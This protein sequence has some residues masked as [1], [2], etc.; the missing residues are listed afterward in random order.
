MRMDLGHAVG[1][2]MHAVWHCGVLDACCGVLDACYGVLDACCG[3]LDACCGVL[4]ACYGVPDSVSVEGATAE[5][6]TASTPE[7]M[8]AAG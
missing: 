2:S 4:D 5:L 1:Y 6:A 7:V 8:L 3:V